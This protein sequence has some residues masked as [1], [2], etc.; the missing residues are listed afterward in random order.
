M[1]KSFL[2]ISGKG[3]VGK[4]TLAAGLAVAAARKGK[5]VALIDGDIGLRSLDLFLGLQNKVLYDLADLVARR[6]TL[7]QTMIW[8]D[9]YASLCL[10]VGGQQ[11]KPKDFRRQDLNK[12]LRTLKKSFDMVFVDGPAGLGRGIRNFVGLTDEV[13]IL[14][15]PDPVSLRS[16]EKLASQLYAEEIRPF[17][18]LNRVS[19]DLVLSGK[20]QQPRMLSM[21]LD[22]PLIGVV[23]ECPSI[24][25]ALL[26][27][28]TAAQ[29]QETALNSAI[30]NILARLEGEEKEIHD[31]LPVERTWFE[32]FVEWLEK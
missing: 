13:L 32:R 26:S 23:E 31:Y 7:D 24:Y 5:R 22:L 14:A 25:E 17:L 29:T 28:K 30:E 20:I 19:P 10:I 6:C 16:A 4:S 21:N 27:G 11:A 12:I 2:F 18:L 1:G 9:S 3:G 8:H 15:T